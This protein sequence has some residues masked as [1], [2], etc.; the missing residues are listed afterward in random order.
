AGLFWI[1]LFYP[2]FRDDPVQ[3]PSV[4]AAEMELI[5][6]DQP[7]P[8]SREH[9][10]LDAPH[11]LALVTNRSILAITIAYLC[12]SFSWSFFVSWMPRYL[13]NVQHL[14]VQNSKW[15]STGPLL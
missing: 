15:I 14:S 8:E 10:R 2:W 11:W 5:R 1:A 13:A 4:N 6:R 9:R 3:K 7:P 12:T